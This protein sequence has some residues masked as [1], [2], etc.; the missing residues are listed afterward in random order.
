MSPEAPP[1]RL[2]EPPPPGPADRR[3]F[4]EEQQLVNIVQGPGPGFFPFWLGLIGGVLG[5][6]IAVDTR[7]LRCYS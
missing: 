3:T 2:A 5:Q 7:R 1:S 6:S 4:D